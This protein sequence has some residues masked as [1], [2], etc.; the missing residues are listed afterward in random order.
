MD[1]FPVVL[2]FSLCLMFTLVVV[3]LIDHSKKCN[4]CAS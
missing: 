2:G 3:D 4:R 1:W